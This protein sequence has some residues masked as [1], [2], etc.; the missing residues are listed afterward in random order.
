MNFFKILN[1]YFFIKFSKKIRPYLISIC[2]FSFIL[3]LY[4]SI[5]SSPQDYQQGEAVRIMYVHVPAAWLALMIFTLIGILSIS[6]LIW[7]AS[8]AFHIA[9]AA[10]PIGAL[11]SLICLLTGMI[12]GKPIWGTWWVWDA[13]LTSMFILFLFY[14][15][16]ISISNGSSNFKKIEK[17]ACVIGI[18]GMI[19]VPIVKFSVDLWYSLHQGPSILRAGGPAIDISMLSPLLIMFFANIIFFL[20]ILGLRVEIIYNNLKSDKNR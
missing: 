7:S 6:C 15:V 19:N 3:G 14:V 10:A 1:P 13:R 20:I 4:L 9:F 18:L 17:P 5:F 2:I 16:F 8:F 12:W 11:Y